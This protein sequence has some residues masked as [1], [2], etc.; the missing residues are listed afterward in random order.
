MN[1]LGRDTLQ[2]LG[3]E[4]SYKT[5][6]EK[7]HNIQPIQNNIAKWIFEKYPHLCTR[8]GKSKNHIAKSTFHNSFHP[9]QHKGRRVPLH[10]LD[11]VERE[12]NKLIED[13]Q[14]IKLDK[15]S[16]EYFISPVVITVKHD[17]SIKIALDSK[18]LNDA[19][20]KNKYQMQ[21]LDHMLDTIACKISELKQKTGTLYFSNI[22]LKY[23][24]SQVPLHEETQK[25]STS[26]FWEETLQERTDS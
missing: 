1:L 21:S 22:D 10:L 3:I 5:P 8:I 18:K 9:T 11:K 4:L 25:H 15:S 2:K 7:I 20:H 23:A 16:D 14:I 17:K 12:L 13:K 24:Y 26:I 19:I 6:G